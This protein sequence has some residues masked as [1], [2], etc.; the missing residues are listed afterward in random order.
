V[1]V[2]AAKDPVISRPLDELLTVLGAVVE[3][4]TAEHAALARDAD[5]DVER[6]SGHQARLDLGDC[7][8]SG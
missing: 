3:P 7:F 1:V 2:D 6:G 4:F 5:R 8:S